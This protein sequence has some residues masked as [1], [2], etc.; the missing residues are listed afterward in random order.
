MTDRYVKRVC[1]QW[2]KNTLLLGLTGSTIIYTY[3]TYTLAFQV[4]LQQIFPPS[5]W[6]QRFSLLAVEPRLSG[7]LM[8]YPSSTCEMQSELGKVTGLHNRT[9]YKNVNIF[10]QC[11]K[12]SS[13]LR[14]NVCDGL[15]KKTLLPGMHYSRTIHWK[16]LVDLLNL[17]H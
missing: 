14:R 2:L 11:W 17:K 7:I 8:L 6:A 13:G 5:C 9:C 4:G 3:A 10:F 1:K 16:F 15:S 12:V